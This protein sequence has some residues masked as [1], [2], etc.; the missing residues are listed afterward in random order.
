M[1]HK[2]L[3]QLKDGRAHINEVDVQVCPDNV[4]MFKSLY[5]LSGHVLCYH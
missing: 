4:P 3:E 1:S 5:L 2:K